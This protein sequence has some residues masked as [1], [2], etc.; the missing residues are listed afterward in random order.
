MKTRSARSV[1]RD[2]FLLRHAMLYIKHEGGVAFCQLV[3]E[4]KEEVQREEI[5]R[6]EVSYGV[7]HEDPSLPIEDAISSDPTPEQ[8]VVERRSYEKL[9]EIVSELEPEAAQIIWLIYGS[10]LTHEDVGVRLECSGSLA[11]KKIRRVLNMLRYQ[12]SVR[13]L[14]WKDFV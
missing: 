2:D 3:I 14:T 8:C 9:R 13:G 12:M 7:T 11:R 4:V 5:L 10:D 1:A 6:A